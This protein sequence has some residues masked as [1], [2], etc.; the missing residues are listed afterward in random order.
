MSV[1]WAYCAQDRCCSALAIG[2]VGSFGGVGF[3][4]GYKSMIRG[5][6]HC[7]LAFVDAMA[8]SCSIVAI[9]VWVNKLGERY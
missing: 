7:D 4:P 2:A 1:S 9:Y 6:C 3:E 8:N 5:V